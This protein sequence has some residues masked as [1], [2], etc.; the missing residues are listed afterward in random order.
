MGGNFSR[1]NAEAK[2]KTSGRAGAWTNLDMKILSVSWKLPV[3][4]W[5]P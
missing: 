3:D 1:K 2:F 4:W 5:A